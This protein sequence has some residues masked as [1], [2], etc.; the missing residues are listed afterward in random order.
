[1]RTNEEWDQ[2]LRELYWNVEHGEHGLA[3]AKLRGF[4]LDARKQ[5]MTDAAEICDYEGGQ[6]SPFG[7]GRKIE[8]GFKTKILN[9]R[10]QLK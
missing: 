8:F 5:G 10:N 1:M 2:I 7:I 9:A 4:E 6:L 3:I